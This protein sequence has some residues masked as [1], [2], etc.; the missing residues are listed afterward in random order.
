MTK[1]TTTLYPAVFSIQKYTL[2]S[3]EILQINISFISEVTINEND[4]YTGSLATELF[5]EKKN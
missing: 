2:I 5:E 3:V 4:N 1:I